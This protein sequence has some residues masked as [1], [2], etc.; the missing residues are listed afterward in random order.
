MRH[1]NEKVDA[2]MREVSSGLPYQDGALLLQQTGKESRHARELCSKAIDRYSN[3]LLHGVIPD[4]L[5]PSGTPS[6]AMSN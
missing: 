3:F 4:D 6:A 5:K 1:R 2:A